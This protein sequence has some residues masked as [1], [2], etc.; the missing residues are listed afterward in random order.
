[1][2]HEVLCAT[3]QALIRRRQALI[4]RRS[5][6]IV[7]FVISQKIQEGHAS[8]SAVHNTHVKVLMESN[9]NGF[10]DHRQ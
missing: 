9:M 2:A 4:R 7:G 8:F 5:D 1:M 6:Y 10:T 3:A